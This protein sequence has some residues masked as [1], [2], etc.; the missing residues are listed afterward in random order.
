[1]KAIDDSWYCYANPISEHVW[2]DTSLS[3]AAKGLLIF[4]ADSSN[5]MNFAE[6]DPPDDRPWTGIPLEDLS[7]SD[8]EEDIRDILRMLKSS[9]YIK[10]RIKDGVA[11]VK[12][13]GKHRP[14]AAYRVFSEVEGN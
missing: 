13:L 10:L 4:L 6:G 8:T 7:A 2:L 3:W 9:G 11:K 14:G 1:M 5:K 12:L